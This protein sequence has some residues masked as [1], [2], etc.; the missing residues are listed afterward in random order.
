[1]PLKCYL[2]CCVLSDWLSERCKLKHGVMWMFWVVSDRVARG[3]YCSQRSTHRWHL[4]SLCSN[5]A[6][7]QWHSNAICNATAACKWQRSVHICSWS[8]CNFQIRVWPFRLR[9]NVSG[10]WTYCKCQ[11]RVWLICLSVAACIEVLW[12]RWQRR[13]I[14]FRGMESAQFWISINKLPVS[15]LVYTTFE[16]RPY[17]VLFEQGRDILSYVVKH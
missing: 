7:M 3:Y 17:K 8:Y 10:P 11:I 13:V 2:T 6:V 1:M 16:D 15:V 4:S 9:W 12:L 14:Y 5:D